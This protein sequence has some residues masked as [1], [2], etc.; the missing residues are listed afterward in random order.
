MRDAGIVDQDGDGAEGFLGGIVCAR[1]GGAVG[2]VGLDGD[3]LAAL[4]LDF[5]F[6]RFKPLDPPRHQRDRGAVVRQR[7]GELHAQPAGGAGDQRNAALQV[8]HVGGFHG[9]TLIHTR[10]T[11]HE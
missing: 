5:I 2:D 8:E 9:S 7:A 11:R 3:G 4:V 1:H 6:Q 10:A